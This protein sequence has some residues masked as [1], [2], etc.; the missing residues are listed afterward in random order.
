MPAKPLRVMLTAFTHAAI[1]NA[2]RKIAELQRRTRR[3]TK[4]TCPLGQA[5]RGS[6]TDAGPRDRTR[7]IATPAMVGSQRNEIGSPRPGRSGR[8]VGPSPARADLVVIDEGSQVLVPQSVDRR[9]AGSQTSGRLVIA[10]D[11]RQL[12]PIVLGAYPEPD[13]GRAA[14]SPL[15]L[16]VPSPR[17]PRGRAHRD[18]ARELAHERDALPLPARADLRPRV[19]ERD[20]ARSRPGRLALGKGA[21]RRGPTTVLDPEY[22]LV[23]CVLEGVQATAENVIEAGLVADVAT[24]LRQRAARLRREALRGHRAADDARLLE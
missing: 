24:R 17:R 19:R 6:A 15:D 5:R 7:S 22:P 1:E 13:E 12:P 20:T 23:V 10:G 2:L 21:E 18:A 16:R 11:D 4:A 3:S 8:C 14:A 9:F